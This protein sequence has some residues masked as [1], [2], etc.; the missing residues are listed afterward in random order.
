MRYLARIHIY[1][2]H[3]LLNGYSIAEQIGE[4]LPSS[5]VGCI[6]WRNKYRYEALNKAQSL[7]IHHWG[8]RMP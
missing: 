8:E 6:K 7:D 3:V 4:I 2:L 1:L 5:R